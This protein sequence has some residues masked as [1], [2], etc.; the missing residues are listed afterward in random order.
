MLGYVQNDIIYI[1]NE[2][3]R[4]KY[5]SL[6]PVDNINHLDQYNEVFSFA[7]NTKDILNIAVS[8]PY[9]SGKSS[10][11]KSC[12]KK[13]GK[14]N[15]TIFVSLAAFNYDKKLFNGNDGEEN[16]GEKAR[17]AM[18][19]KLEEKILKQILYTGKPNDFAKS[20][21]R[22]ITDSFSLNDLLYSMV[23]AIVLTFLI[24]RACLNMIKA[25]IE[26]IPKI[27]PFLIYAFFAVLLFILITIIVFFAKNRGIVFEVNFSNASIKNKTKDNDDSSILNRNIDELLYFFEK[28]KKEIVVIED[29]DRFGDTNIFVSLREINA[30]INNSP[31][32]NHE[33]RFIYA[34]KDDLLT[35]DGERTKFF[36]FII[37]VIPY[38][39]S[40][41]SNEV[42]YKKL[43]ISDK[44]GKSELYDISASFVYA[45]SP[46]IN[47]ARTLSNIVN[48]FVLMNDI[49]KTNQ[50][51]D[52]KDEKMFSLVTIKNLY[53]EEFA[54]LEQESN[55]SIIIK[56]FNNKEKFVG[57]KN[58]LLQTKKS[59][60][61]AWFKDLNDGI[62][63]DIK[64]LKTAWFN[65]ISG[66][67]QG[68]N[69]IIDGRS[70]G[71]AQFLDDNFDVKLLM[72]PIQLHNGYNASNIQQNE[73]ATHY[74]ERIYHL[75]DGIEKAKT[76]SQERI[77]E[78][79][80][81]LDQI[82]LYSI[83]EIIRYFNDEFNEYLPD[84][85]LIV[86]LLKSG[87]LDESY[88]NYINYFYSN[89]KTKEEQN[90]V[91]SVH[92][93]SGRDNSE[94]KLPHA[95]QVFRSLTTSEFSQ[96]ESLNYDLL[97]YLIGTKS[98]TEAL[99]LYLQQIS[100][101]SDRS[102]IFINTYL[103]NNRSYPDLLIK[104]VC[105][106]NSLFW[107]TVKNDSKNT[108]NKRNDILCK[109]I[110]Y[111]DVEDI[112]NQDLGRSEIKKG[113]LGEYILSLPNYFKITK[114][115]K[116][117]KTIEVIKALGLLFED[118]D[119]EEADQIVKKFFFEESRY[120]LNRLMI[121]KLFEWKCPEKT[122]RLEEKNYT[123]ILE[124]NY[125][126]LI[127]YVHDKFE[128]YIKEIVLGI[129]TNDQENVEAVKDMVE[130]LSAN[131]TG[132]CFDVLDKENVVFES[133]NE[134]LPNFDAADDEKKKI[135][136][137]LIRNNR[138]NC[139]WKNV[140]DYYI[141]YGCNNQ[142]VSYIE[143]NHT[144]LFNGTSE[145]HFPEE[146]YYDL[147]KSITSIDCFKSF[148]NYQKTVIYNRDL[149]FLDDYKIELLIEEKVLPFTEE[150]WK[151]L[152]DIGQGLRIKYALANRDS[153]MESVD[154]LIISEEE[155][156]QLIS[157]EKFTNDDKTAIL[158]RIEPEDITE[159]TAEIIKTAHFNVGK[160]YVEVSFQILPVRERYEL[161]INFIHMFTKDE[162]SEM[163]SELDEPYHQLI[164]TEQRHRYTLYS[165]DYN[166]RLIA[167][168]KGM[169]YL[170]V[171][172][173]ESI[174]G[175]DGAELILITGTVKRK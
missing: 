92:N 23:I 70:Y 155:I 170:T 100:D 1:M 137:Y 118:V 150:Y 10:V 77:S 108:E 151:D 98:G 166:E 132:L 93:L 123:S 30:L 78:F 121:K 74:I 95:E 62:F 106:K 41:N 158:S 105:N 91:L 149:S 115:V 119:I 45:I 90:F 138:I 136:D 8:G 24:C 56:T 84:N 65:I 33:V 110:A 141:N 55:E 89:S 172:R 127:N 59:K 54:K 160:Q 22:R 165:T 71:L 47:D 64:D 139:N 32:K 11:I 99:D 63:A 85:G 43:E 102:N 168:L 107:E 169:D 135:W 163:F 175:P 128:E 79:E 5:V 19:A 4:E 46:Y 164:R 39:S 124:L 125:E 9:G 129:D 140:L 97:D 25:I 103:E 29:L 81:K 21:F 143:R 113:E 7:L 156:C 146:A 68:T 38:I 148:I 16:N 130:R 162:L 42:L 73:K 26:F 153:F 27:P 17:E 53:P 49:L 75:S 60:E 14:T 120:R 88:K 116:P 157:N 114:D 174:S 69:I 15:E 50:Q 20:R 147:L 145:S 82:K 159:K 3:K 31:T 44:T 51:L 86:F 109:I 101:N 80:R 117:H 94:L 96:K 104:D 28:A 167:K 6:A 66:F 40:S 173:K 18:E 12:I 171:L 122:Y 126:P 36:D 67:R 152:N 133:I 61:E 37:P 13:A 161:L 58:A 87:Y 35:K 72:K 131:Q 154:E 2:D 52:L 144:N 83:K 57:E 112:V 76:D 142:W 48:E 134:I 111:A 34:V